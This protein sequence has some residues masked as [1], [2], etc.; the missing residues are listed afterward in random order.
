MEEFNGSF[1]SSS[2]FG[3]HDVGLGGKNFAEMSHHEAVLRNLFLYRKASLKEN[4]PKTIRHLI[5][6]PKKPVLVLKPSYLSLN[7]FLD[8][9][10]CATFN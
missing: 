2:W 6:A 10:R 5:L 9:V 4:A 3:D 8:L 1:K 7:V